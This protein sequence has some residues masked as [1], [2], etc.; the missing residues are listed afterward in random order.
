MSPSRLI[1]DS[2]GLLLLAFSLIG[3]SAP[4]A[5]LYGQV[6]AVLSGEQIRVNISGGQ[7]RQVKLLGIQTS[8]HSRQA[9]ADAKRHL[10][11]LLAG[12]HIT[13]EY[14]TVMANGVILGI[15]R[16]GGSDIA[17]RMLQAGLAKVAD[18]A[19]LEPDTRRL[20]QASEFQARNRKM[21]LWQLK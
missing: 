1:P 7:T 21:G 17:L 11:M 12:R 2:L 16:H 4:A 20:Y 3:N 5:S 6:S 9:F 10:S 18:L 13:V 15:V 19:H 8:S 14:R